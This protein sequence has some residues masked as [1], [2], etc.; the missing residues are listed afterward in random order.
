M[1]TLHFCPLF[2]LSIAAIA[3]GPL[4]PDDLEDLSITGLTAPPTSGNVDS[5]TSG[6]ETTGDAP[7]TG[8]IGCEVH[9]IFVAP[10]SPE[11]RPWMRVLHSCSTNEISVEAFKWRLRSMS[12]NSESN[13][14]L[15]P[16]E[17]NY[18][19][20]L[21]ENCAIVMWSSYAKAPAFG[22]RRDGIYM[23]THEEVEG[24]IPGDHQ[25]A[26]R[27]TDPDLPWVAVEDAMIGKPTCKGFE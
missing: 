7:T 10:D 19:D 5:T 4:Q 6:E 2:L 15:I 18:P 3:C 9:P 1:R 23:L 13:H 26:M 14:G 22:L 12:T 8:E 17:D 24:W 11:E 20:T 25:G 21:T 16:I 27:P